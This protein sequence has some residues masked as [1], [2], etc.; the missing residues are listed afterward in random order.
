MNSLEAKEIFTISRSLKG[1]LEILF[2]P[3]KF[4][5]SALG[6]VYPRL[7]IHIIPRYK[8]ERIFESIPFLDE[9]W[10]QNYA[11]YNKSFHTPSEILQEI[12]R[13]IKN[14]LS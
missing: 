12:K 11:P 8:S 4:N 6:N 14:L 7:H 2:H 9:R 5:Y 13:K 3:D 10:G 1:A